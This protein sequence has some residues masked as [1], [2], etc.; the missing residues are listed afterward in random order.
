L[1]SLNIRFCA[2][3]L[4]APKRKAQQPSLQLWALQAQE[5]H[6]PKGIT[7]ILWQLLTMQQLEAMTKV[8]NLCHSTKQR[9]KC[10]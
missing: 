5:V 10:G 2:V 4:K 8:W 6:Q 7:A 1:A 9:Q 3:Q